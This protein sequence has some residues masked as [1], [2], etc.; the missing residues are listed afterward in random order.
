MSKE[1][2]TFKEPRRVLSPY[3]QTQRS[4]FYRL[5]ECKARTHESTESRQRRIFVKAKRSVDPTLRG[6]G[7]EVFD[8]DLHSAL[9]REF[10]RRFVS[11]VIKSNSNILTRDAGSQS[12]P[13]SKSLTGRDNQEKTR[14]A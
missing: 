6:E 4:K 2:E 3:Q 10:G 11:Q 14:R 8:K 7:R 1:S 5:L 13:V 12:L 9:L